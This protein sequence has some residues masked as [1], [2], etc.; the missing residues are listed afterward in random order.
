MLHQDYKFESR[1][2]YPEMRALDEGVSELFSRASEVA[3]PTWDALRA[4]M[5]DW[6]E[7]ERIWQS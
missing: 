1:A 4:A 3:H 6:D 7:L 2:L 5:P